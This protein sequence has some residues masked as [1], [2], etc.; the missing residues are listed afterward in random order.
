MS[1]IFFHIVLY[2]FLTLVAF[3]AFSSC[4]KD[5]EPEKKKE[6]TYTFKYNADNV[7]GVTID[8]FI[9]EYN[10]VGEI[11]GQQS[12]DNCVKGFQREFTANSK[13]TKVKVRI[14]INV[15]SSYSIRW[16]QQVFYLEIGKNINIETNNNT[17][18]GPSEP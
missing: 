8:V 13:A 2:T 1:R 12:F 15:G 14:R 18:V 16:I 11:V 7:S 4:S 17:I 10:D 3:I 5:E 9:F 6:T